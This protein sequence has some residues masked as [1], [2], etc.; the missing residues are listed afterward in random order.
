MGPAVGSR[1]VSRRPAERLTNE[2]L[3]AA[4]NTERRIEVVG[5]GRCVAESIMT[6]FGA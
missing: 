2:S 4:G 3:G 5:R 6:R 1:A